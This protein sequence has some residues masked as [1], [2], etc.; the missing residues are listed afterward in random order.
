MVKEAEKLVRKY[1]PKVKEIITTADWMVAI[2]NKQGNLKMD[3]PHVKICQPFAKQSE[4]F[5]KFII[6]VLK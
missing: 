1:N 4:E 6:N 3:T 2:Q 5:H